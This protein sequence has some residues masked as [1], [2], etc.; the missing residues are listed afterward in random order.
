MG[1]VVPIVLRPSIF[2]RAGTDGD[3]GWM[4]EQPRWQNALFIFNDN[5]S[6]SQAF[7]A[8]V[9]SGH[10]DPS[11]YACQA[12]G[13]NAVIRPYQCQTRRRAAGVPTGPGY[14][15]L[16]DHAKSQIDDAIA[17]V[18]TLLASDTGL[19]EVIYSA[20]KDDPSMLGHGIFDVGDDVLRYIPAELKRV[21]D[22]ANGA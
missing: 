21:V 20:S 10:I 12:G 14:A 5:E 18:G 4:I 8:Q 11:S 13:G 2:S 17:S 7:L 15:S 16:I 9:A 1:S 22:K 3:F 6:Q 19:A